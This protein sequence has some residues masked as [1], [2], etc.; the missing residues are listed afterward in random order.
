[1]SGSATAAGRHSLDLPTDAWF[2]WD[3]DWLAVRG[4]T[5]WTR[6]TDIPARR[7]GGDPAGRFPRRRPPLRHAVRAGT[8]SRAAGFFLGRRPADPDVLDDLRPVFLVL[9]PETG[10]RR[11]S[12][13]LPAIGTVNVWRL[14]IEDEESDGTLLASAQDPVT[15]PCLLL[16]G[17]TLAA[18][19]MLKRLPP[20]FDATGVVVTRH[21][22][23][24][25]DGERIPYVMSGP[26]GETGDAPVHLTGY[27]GFGISSLPNYSIAAGK[28]WLERGGTSVMA[29]SEAAAS[30]ARAGTKPAAVPASG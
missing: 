13:G 15:P 9:T 19:E 21:E 3:A 8:A 18:P 17:A 10:S 27:G 25:V 1:M 6:G 12:A 11:R 20:A 22:A 2:T 28:L 30:S 5:A 23:V 24:S 26:A 4:R 7:G 16:T 29:I 14:D